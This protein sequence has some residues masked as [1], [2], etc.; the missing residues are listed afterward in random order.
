[1]K[2][3]PNWIAHSLR[4]VGILHIFL[5]AVL[6]IFPG[7]LPEQYNLN[8]WVPLGCIG[9]L[10]FGTGYF[11]ASY[12]PVRNSLA[13]V[14]GL[15]ASFLAGL[16]LSVYAS[17]ALGGR[18][19]VIV[20]GLIIAWAGTLLAML[21]H[22]SKAGQAPKALAHTFSEPLSRTLSRFRTQRGKNLLQL[23]NRQPILLVFLRHFGSPF[24]REALADI[25]R[26]QASIEGEGTRLVFVHLAEEEQA[27]R[28]FEKA[29]LQNEHRISDP[30]GIMYNAFKLD[31][32]DFTQVFGWQSWFRRIG[33]TVKGHGSGLVVGDG[34]R[35]PGVFL[36]NE[37]EII[38]SYRHAN[39]SDR[40]DY[41]S[42]AS[43]KAA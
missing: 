11:I 37:G 14:M 12:N 16:F 41:I 13:L 22:I 2:K 25:K 38:K 27:R 42:L 4:T 6:L 43:R 9:L 33:A 19:L 3:L 30:N 5:A 34:F 39:S 18:A 23:S 40:P 32:A 10:V 8:L 28:Y 7:I 31:R 36:I 29:G 17:E 15:L 35:M 20:L 24:C 1:M 21:Y 26:Q